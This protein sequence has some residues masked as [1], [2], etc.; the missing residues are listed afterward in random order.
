MKYD[1]AIGVGII[2][3]GVRGLDSI[4]R[5]MAMHFA[6]TGFKAQEAISIGDDLHKEILPPKKMG[7]KTILVKHWNYGEDEMAHADHVIESLAELP[8]AVK[9]LIND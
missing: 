5:V 6:D 1:T 7:M 9:K 3:T 2:G 8:S 4:A